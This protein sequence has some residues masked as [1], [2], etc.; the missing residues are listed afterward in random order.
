PAIGYKSVDAVSVMARA[1]GLTPIAQDA[2]PANNLLLTFAVP[3]GFLEVKPSSPSS[4]RAAAWFVVE[5]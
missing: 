5:F 2:M 1:A 3:Q 4:M